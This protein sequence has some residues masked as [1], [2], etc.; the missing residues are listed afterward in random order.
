MKRLIINIS[1]ILA[2]SFASAAQIRLGS[3]DFTEQHLLSAMTRLYLEEKGF[4]VTATT[5]LPSVILRGAL[6]NNQLDLVWDYT[7]TAL[8]VYH[9]LTEVNPEQSYERVKELD[10]PN[11][12]VWLKPA[13]MNNTYAF[14]MQRKRAEALGISTMS[15]MVKQFNQH[16]NWK[17]GLDIE[18]AGRPDGLKPMQEKYQ[19]TLDRPQMK[20]MNSGLVYNAIR[21]GFVDVGLVYATDGRVKG[22]DFIILE[23]DLHF[24]PSYA[25]TPV[26]EKSVLDANPGLEEALN[27]LSALLDND[28][29]STLNAKVDIEHLRVDEVA[30]QFLKDK[31]LLQGK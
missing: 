30:A 23:D 12:L 5:D 4:E 21:D 26:V 11:G 25:A 6:I 20:Q 10:I 15:G 29:I 27:T 24:F 1:L 31:G 18:F 8:I 7:G 19:L 22:F 9:K 16:K 14:A 3:K 17:I 13:A 2:A 28:T